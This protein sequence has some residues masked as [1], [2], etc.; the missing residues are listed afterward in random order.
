MTTAGARAP[1][2]VLVID[3]ELP[4]LDELTWL[5]ERDP[6][7]GAVHRSGSGTEALRLLKERRQ[8]LSNGGQEQAR[9]L[10]E[11]RPALERI[12]AA[13]ESVTMSVLRIRCHGDYHLGQVLYTG[14]DFVHSSRFHDH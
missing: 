1:L 8:F 11:F 2:R 3:D 7:V 13:F 5:L 6:R 4:A 10:L 12:I 9:R 14:K